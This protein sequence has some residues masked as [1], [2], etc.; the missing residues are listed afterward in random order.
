MSIKE[1]Q[2]QVGYGF[3]TTVGYTNNGTVFVVNDNKDEDERPV[4]MISEFSPER[5][6]DIAKSLTKAAKEAR[7]A[8]KAAH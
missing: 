6:E 1:I 5:A 8:S 2:Q 3:G 7:K 4:Q